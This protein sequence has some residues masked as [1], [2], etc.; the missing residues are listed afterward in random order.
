MATQRVTTQAEAARLLGVTPMTVRRWI[1]TGLLA[2]PPW[3][4][5]TLRVAAR[6][7]TRRRETH[8]SPPIGS[9]AEHGTASRWRAGCDCDACRA[10]HTGDTTS[11]R[12][13]AR[14]TW[15]AQREAAF[16][17]DLASGATYREAL[18]AQEIS[19]N[20]VAA[21]RRRDPTFAA[22]LW[23]ALE[24]GRD[25]SL[26]HGTSGAWRYGRCRCR[27]CWEHHERHR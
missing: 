21:R 22:R 20:A 6:L 26:E 10:A 13:A 16:L 19:A 8:G 11:R 7:A 4:R 27:E 5:R 23:D 15:W 24:A 2:E 1:S 25:P 12:A 17:D 14:A 9:S 3:T 18:E